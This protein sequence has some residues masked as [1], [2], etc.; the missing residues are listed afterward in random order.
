MTVLYGIKNCDTVKKARH[1]LDKHAIAYRFHDF[2]AD[3]LDQKR[4]ARWVKQLG[5]E[6]LL[7]RRGATWRQLPDAQRERISDAVGAVDA[8][9]THVALIK[10]PVLE[11][12]RALY[13][14]F[15]ADD[16]AELLKK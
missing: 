15:S 12:D 13:V 11:S 8:M 5:W 1:W 14:G 2:R 9:L 6:S 10:R 7:N 3:G 4:L 16:Y